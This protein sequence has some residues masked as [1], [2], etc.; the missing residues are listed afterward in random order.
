MTSLCS[1]FRYFSLY[2]IIYSLIVTAHAK[3]RIR[4]MLGFIIITIIGC[5][6]L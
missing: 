3:R 4:I 6:Y 5:I 2:N 1:I